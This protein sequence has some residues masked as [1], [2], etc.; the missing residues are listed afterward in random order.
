MTYND[1]LGL[2]ET[3]L[4]EPPG[5]ITKTTE[6]KSLGSW[7]SVGILS[8]MALVDSSVGVVL[9]PEQLAKST[10]AGDLLDLIRDR[11]E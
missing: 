5:T 2:L 3:A 7:D 10:T 9:A 6:L 1:A 4:N 8:V 11:L